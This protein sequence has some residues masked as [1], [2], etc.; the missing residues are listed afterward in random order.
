M[1]GF[2]LANLD[3]AGT[4]MLFGHKFFVKLSLFHVSI[5]GSLG[6]Y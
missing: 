3:M 2:A 6:L 1:G 5:F 4:G